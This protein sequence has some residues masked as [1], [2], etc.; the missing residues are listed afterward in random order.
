[1]FKDKATKVYPEDF[2]VTLFLHRPDDQS[3]A[4]EMATPLPGNVG[5]ANCGRRQ[6]HPS[7]HSS[8]SE[9]DTTDSNSE[10]INAALGGSS[11]SPAVIPMTASSKQQHVFQS[12]WI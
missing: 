1:M 3:D 7:Q 4:V 8:S 5:S 12:D 10:V 9:E 2:S 11:S 6:Q